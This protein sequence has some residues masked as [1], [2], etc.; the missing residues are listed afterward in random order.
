MSVIF[1]LSTQCYTKG[2]YKKDELQTNP[3]CCFHC[4][5]MLQPLICGQWI[6]LFNDVS[7]LLLT[8]S[9]KN[10]NITMLPRLGSLPVIPL[11][12]KTKCKFYN[13]CTKENWTLQHNFYIIVESQ[14]PAKTL[15]TSLHSNQRKIQQTMEYVPINTAT[16]CG[17][18]QGR[19][20]LRFS[21]IAHS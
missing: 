16:W 7:S 4:P 14:V 2:P 9:K 3:R 13:S 19:G 18:Q 20:P 11:S 5:T 1:T 6:P 17:G 15:L 12:T 10:H 8:D 21:M